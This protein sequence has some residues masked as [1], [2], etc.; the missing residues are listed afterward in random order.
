MGLAQYKQKRHFS[1]TPEPGPDQK[2][3]TGWRYV[4]Q[5]HDASHLHYDFRLE[6]DGVLKS[7]AVPKG[8][9]LDPSIKR[10]AIE[11]EDH[12]VAYAQFEG[13]IPQGQYGGGT[14]MLWDQGDWEPVGDPHKGLQQGK[15]KF[16]LKGQKLRGGWTL[17]RTH[18]SNSSSPQWLLIKDR[19]AEASSSSD[20]DILETASLSVTTG[21]DLDEIAAGTD[22]PKSLK[23][24]ILPASKSPAEASQKR[25]ATATQGHTQSS[26]ATPLPTTIDVQ[27]ATLV[28]SP[29]EGDQWFH[30]IKFDGY[31]MICRIDQGSVSFISRNHQDWTERLAPLAE[32]ASHIKARQVL[33]DGEV[34]AMRPD[35][36]TDFQ[37][38][39]NAF[40]DHRVNDLKYYAFDIL[41][42]D[43][44]SL[45]EKTLQER[46]SRLWELLQSSS[47]D[48]SI[49]YSE[50]VT[51]GGE[52]FKNQA[53][54]LHLEGMVSKRR[55]QP[56][57][58][59]RGLD[60]VKTKCLHKDEF[61]IGGYTEP[62]GRRTGL[63]ALLVGFHDSSGNLRYAGK[64]GTGFDEQTLQDLVQ[65]FQPLEQSKSP[66][67]DAQTRTGDLRTAH[68][69]KPSL[70][71]QFNYGSRTQDGRLRHASYQGLREDKPAQEVHLD[72]P[73]PAGSVTTEKG[74]ESTTQ[75]AGR[76]RKAG[77]S[78]EMGPADSASPLSSSY[79]EE[80]GKLAG[81][82]FTHPDK[83][84]YP[85]DKITKQDLA[86]YF[87]AVA[88]W[89]LPH[90]RHR[91]LVIVRCPEGQTKE[92]FYQK[93]PGIGTPSDLRQIPISEK[94]KV[95][96][97]LVV[98]N[99]KGLVALA[100]VSALELH[101]WGS[102]EDKMERPDRLIFDLDP[103]PEVNWK[104]VIECANSI[105]EFLEGLGLKSFVKTTG[106]KGLHIVIPIDRRHEWDD[107]KDFCKT[108]ADC[109]VQA[110][111]DLFTANMS[112]AARTGKIFVD[113]LR[114]GRG[115]TSV[116]PYSPRA[117]E[118]APVS[119]PIDWSELTP[120]LTSTQFT[121]R[122]VINRLSALSQDPW[123]DFES[124][125]QSLAKPIRAITSLTRR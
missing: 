122:N 40:R 13:T 28:E 92:C 73:L 107:V 87:I 118:H 9:S 50:H 48:D 124:T 62:S 70:V 109:L 46:K 30:E 64:V 54:R 6:L 125:R 37:S 24:G 103:A 12:P 53:C 80:A 2:R 69:I 83:L 49:R 32:S 65:R 5:K 29:P 99:A 21:R 120:R 56:Y 117:R 17:I 4:I 63:G 119:V 71:G 20:Q 23:K 27:L 66:F 85:A 22:H 33:L 10:L 7:W 1:R 59:G 111:P 76:S 123:S 61:V 108:V 11:V 82:R 41:F 105:R 39:Q 112:K 38:L 95:E 74:S 98:D 47:L 52:A 81:V 26:P 91:P 68:W 34:V 60:W 88:D 79:D 19:D 31:R 44:E 110:Q 36:T 86:E 51:G 100:Q 72:Q 84:V 102:R 93:H 15:L 67:V 90:L 75:T 35:G 97:Y 58:A 57:H 89:I 77:K 78:A 94:S 96:K 3:A 114:N 101:A 16:L 25:K 45:M 106:G 121:I 115:A 18:R 104:T 8:P 113:Y 14:V 116:V 42:L 55:D 43:G